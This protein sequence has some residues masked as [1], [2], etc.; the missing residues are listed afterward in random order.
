MIEG[1]YVLTCSSY[2]ESFSLVSLNTIDCVAPSCSEKE[3]TAFSKAGA[4]DLSDL[5]GM[6]CTFRLYSETGDPLTPTLAPST[7]SLVDPSHDGG[8]DA[9]VITLVLLIC[10]VIIAAV[11]FVV[12]SRMKNR[13]KPAENATVAYARGE[14]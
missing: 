9:W 3:F 11:I 6:D 8:P 2:G 7:P 1:D 12:F 14:V 4:A 10:V 13:A 5:Y